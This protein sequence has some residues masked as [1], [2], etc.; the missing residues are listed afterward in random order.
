MIPIQIVILLFG[1]RCAQKCQP[2]QEVWLETWP[3]PAPDTNGAS[4]DDRK[5]RKGSACSAPP[6]HPLVSQITNLKMAV[7]NEDQSEFD[8]DVLF[9]RRGR[10]I[11]IYYI[12]IYILINFNLVGL[13]LRNSGTYGVL[14]WT[15]LRLVLFS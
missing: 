7:L 3:V 14:F 12:Y 11:Y 6:F 13:G 8:L 1:E 5:G 2:Y 10:H 15:H 4:T 9:F